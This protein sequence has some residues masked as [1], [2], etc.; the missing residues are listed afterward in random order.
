MKIL[1]I[2]QQPTTLHSFR[3]K[4]A[5]NGGHPT[6][7]G[8]LFCSAATSLCHTGRNGNLV[9]VCLTLDTDEFFTEVRGRTV[10]GIAIAQD[11]SSAV[12]LYT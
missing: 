4:E 12:E 2:F 6:Q 8:N 11:F 1:E 10:K 5:T 9:A 3:E 7:Q